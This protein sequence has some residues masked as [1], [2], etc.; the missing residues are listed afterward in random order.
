M[1]DNANESSIRVLTFNIWGMHGDWES[2]R[3]IISEGIRRLQ[4]DIIAFQEVIVKPGYDQVATLIDDEAYQ[5]LHQQQ[6]LLDDNHYHAAAI[7]SRWAI[8]N[9][10]EVNLHVSPRT[11]RYPSTSLVAQIACPSQIGDIAFVNHGPSYQWFAEY[12]RELQAV[13]AAQE[14]ERRI[15][16]WNVA[17]VI[18][19]GDFNAEPDAASTRF[20]TGKQSLQETSV[21][22]Q[23]TWTVG[24]KQPGYTFAPSNPLTTYDEPHNERPKRIDYILV[25]CEEHGPTL[26]TE[27]VSLAFNK[28][29]HGLYASD[30][31]GVIADLHKSKL[32]NFS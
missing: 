32:S 4:P 23:D 13:T 30:H 26:A 16:E 22:Y 5:I 7:A 17:H 14:I 3:K 25:R 10:A 15:R 18:V 8:K 6:G 28:P 1:I 24:S 21:A 31:F 9:T 11:S 19:A 20:W 27:S 12:E 2:R 29:V